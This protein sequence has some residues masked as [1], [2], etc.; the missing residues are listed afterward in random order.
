MAHVVSD[1]FAST[2]DP[3]WIRTCPGGGAITVARSV[4]RL[5]LP[6]A[7][8]ERYSNAQIDDYSAFP[9]ARY[10]WR[11]PLRLELRARA[12]LPAHP[13]G[14]AAP[15]DHAKQPYLRGTAGFGFWNH[16]FS[17]SGD[18]LRPPEAVW[19]FAASP[20]S[21]MA[22]VPGIPGW[23]WKAQIVHAQRWGA[24]AASVPAL[25]A[26]ARAR[27]TGNDRAASRWV[28]RVSGASEA[29]L[30]A[31]LSEW[32]DYSIE[33]RTEVARFCVDGA[34][35]LAANS[36]PRGRL[37]FVTWIDNQF[38]IATPRGDFRFGTLESGPQW[39]EIDWLRIMSLA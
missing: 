28:Q 29:P 20:P 32:H 23:G 1:D 33:W 35:V 12:S 13:A 31:D 15:A 11:P 8:P 7:V 17:P 19:F 38:A 10:P 34:E 2:L 6:G 22:L 3:R 36:P 18:V 25:G 16:P 26:V 37:G 27:L 4:L 21:N 14:S 9:R 24:L 5:A 39:L 30:M